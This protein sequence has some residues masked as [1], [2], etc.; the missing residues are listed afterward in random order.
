MLDEADYARYLRLAIF[1]EDAL[2]PQDVIHHCWRTI[3]ELDELDAVDICLTLLELSLL[4]S[5]DLATHHARLHDV[6]R[7]NLRIKAGNALPAFQQQC[8]DTY[9][10]SRWVEIPDTPSN[11]NPIDP[12]ASQNNHGS[13]V[14]GE[15]GLCAAQRVCFRGRY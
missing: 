5:Y 15:E 1:P 6:V 8:L 10:V 4:C 12:G 9:T 2:I 13:P 14:P 3:G 11:R 7:G